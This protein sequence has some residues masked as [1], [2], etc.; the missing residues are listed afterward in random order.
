[1]KICIISNLYRPYIIGG[2]EIC[3][4][5]TAN[6]LADCG[7]DVFVITTSPDAG[8]RPSTDISGKIR[9]YKFNP[10]NL[11]H[12]YWAD[13]T[14]AIYKPLWHL[15]DIWNLQPYFAVKNIIKREMPDI[16]HT[17]N[18]GG[19]ST[20]IFS[21]IKCFEIPHFHT[22]H[23]FQLLSPW[24]TLFR[25]GTNVDEFNFLERRFVNIK[26][27]L[28]SSVDVAIS[29]SRFVL[30]THL[31][32]GFFK[33]AK[34]VVLPLG[35]DLG[36]HNSIISKN[37]DRI[38][39]LYVGGLVWHKGVHLLIEAFQSITSEKMMLHI[40]G[41]GKDEEMFWHMAKSDRRIIFHGFVSAEERD[42][43]Y[44]EANIVVVPSIWY[45]NS[46]TVIYESFSHATPVI[47]SRIGGIPELI[48][49]GFNGL[50]FEP[51]NVEDLKVK[52]EYLVSNEKLLALFAEN[53]FILSRN[54]DKFRYLKRL[55]EE[56]YAFCE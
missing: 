8:L 50:L 45:D 48:Q 28:S 6:G 23:D 33:D 36:D 24:S 4:E 56:Y 17:H 7:H 38:N 55:L 51:G 1:M 34:H 15:I 41:K 30:D 18:L 19:F 20:S 44:S 53:T 10:L 35:I 26:R 40:V 37:Y 47:G 5:M 16:I 12:T 14:S 49:D 43:I 21:A 27:I 46:P 9:I 52:I 3:A 54:F 39:L 25:N 2:A 32:H 22:L 13:S 11:Y 31:K 29:P 42:R